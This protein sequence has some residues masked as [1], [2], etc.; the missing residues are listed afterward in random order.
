MPVDLQRQSKNIFAA[1]MADNPLKSLS[2]DDKTA[3]L[4][5]LTVYRYA[6]ETK[7]AAQE[8]PLEKLHKLAHQADVL[9]DA[10]ERDLFNP[11]V[12]NV[13]GPA[14]GSHSD[15]VFKLKAFAKE[16]DHW[17]TLAGARGH[18]GKISA[19]SWL[20]CVS[21]FI[22]L[23]TGEYHDETLAELIFAMED[24]GEEE[25]SP[26]AITKRRTRF[27]ENY[28]EMYDEILEMARTAAQRQ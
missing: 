9:A 21:E 2:E 20:I 24:T 6:D 3:I 1:L 28:P 15:T 25:L 23:K 8:D 11:Q 17:L 18:K 14:L 27:I 10:L 13:L 26:Q 19:T 7:D 16:L 5:F 22:R 12:W 4:A